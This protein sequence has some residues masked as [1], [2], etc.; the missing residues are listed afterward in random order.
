MSLLHMIRFEL[1]DD[2]LFFRIL[3]DYVSQYA[4]S[5]ARGVDFQAMLEDIS[6]TDFSDFFNQWYFGEGF[7]IFDVSWQQ[8]GNLLTLNSKQTTS[9]VNTPLF[10]TPMEYRLIYDSGDS[11]IRVRHE[12]ND[13]VYTI[14]VLNNITV[15]DIEL[16]PNNW[17]LN[18]LAGTVK[19]LDIETPSLL[20]TFF[21]NPGDGIFKFR[22][23]VDGKLKLEVFNQ[24]GQQM[25][26][27][28]YDR[29]SPY[30]EYSLDI[31]DLSE[32][33]YLLKA[34]TA[35]RIETK[36]IILNK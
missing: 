21:P 1:D 35:E 29:V 9:S 8:S 36:R 14:D 26:C 25:K 15:L 12:L 27:I 4:N 6:G 28:E 7:P 13:E 20:T 24:V 30:S 22:L 23:N 32:G 18:D 16:D 5:V 11:I 19:H 34:S 10:K 3:K 17:V 2:E 31:T 33:V